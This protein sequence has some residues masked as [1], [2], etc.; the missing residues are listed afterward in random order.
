MAVVVVALAF[1]VSNGFHDSSNSIAALVATRAARPAPA[2]LMATVFTMLGPILVATAVADTIG[3]IVTL[4]A[5]Q[6]LVVLLSALLA[7][8]AWN[9]FTWYQGLPSSSSHALIGGLVGAGLVMS[10]LSA[11]NWGG[12]SFNAANRKR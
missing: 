9:I 10:G 1:D 11:I 3:G 7:G 5:S 8:L 4:D 2:V 12:I 6:T